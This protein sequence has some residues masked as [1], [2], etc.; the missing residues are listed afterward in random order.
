MTESATGAVDILNPFNG[1]IV[2]SGVI[3]TRMNPDTIEAEAINP[4]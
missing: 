1:T 3:V 2:V 4:L